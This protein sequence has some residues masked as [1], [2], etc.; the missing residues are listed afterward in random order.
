[1]SE[2]FERLIQVGTVTAVDPNAHKVRVKFLDTGLTSDWLSV[3]KN[4]PSV[5][6]S[7]AGAHSHGGS[8]SV[9]SADGHSHGASVSIEQADG[10]RHTASVN[11]WMPAVNDTVLVVY[12]PVFNS[13][14][15]V[16]GGI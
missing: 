5:S 16:I 1:M 3:L 4:A 10:H 6:I 11:L 8:V 15:F 7:T 12:L 13:D 9:N 2:E 14:G